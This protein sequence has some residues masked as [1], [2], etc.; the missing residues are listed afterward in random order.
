M[1]WL[2]RSAS[3]EY[4]CYG[5]TAIIIFLN[6]FSSGTAFRRLNLTSIDVRFRRLQTVRVLKGLVH[7]VLSQMLLC[8]IKNI[9]Y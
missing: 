9:L 8:A 4:L 5:F 6:S 1:S 7:F 3:F 2:A